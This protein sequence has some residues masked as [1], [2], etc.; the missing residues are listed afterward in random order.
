[1][2]AETKRTARGALTLDLLE[3]FVEAASDEM[4]TAVAVQYLACLR[5]GELCSLAVDC[6][7]TGGNLRIGSNKAFRRTNANRVATSQAKPLDEFALR[8]VREAQEAAKKA[9][10]D[11]ED[12]LIT[13][14]PKDYRT[15]FRGAIQ[16]AGIAI[17]GLDFVPHSVR[18]GRVADMKVGAP[19]GVLT[20]AQLDLA[21]MSA[22][23]SVRYGRSNLERVERLRE[24]GPEL[25]SDSDDE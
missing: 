4:G 20:K 6:L 25:E 15:Q 21:G 16:R 5:L 24:V 18:H 19:L 10:R 3:A 17:E 22:A 14:R 9:G 8:A 12:P 23:T 13:I 1:M 11:G 7:T 2:A